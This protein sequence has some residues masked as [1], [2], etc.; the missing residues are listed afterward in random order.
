MHKHDGIDIKQEGPERFPGR[1]EPRGSIFGFLC[2]KVDM[3]VAYT[4][5]FLV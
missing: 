3:T 4:T 2:T 5:L 1:Y